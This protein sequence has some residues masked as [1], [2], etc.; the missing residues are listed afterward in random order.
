MTTRKNSKVITKAPP[1]P[2]IQAPKYDLPWLQSELRTIIDILHANNDIKTKAQLFRDYQFSSSRFYR[3]ITKYNDN[4]RVQEYLKKI[5]EI[6]ES[7]LIE[8]GLEKKNFPFVIFLLKN[9]YGYQDKKEVETE[10]THVFK[11][12]RGNKVID[13]DPKQVKQVLNKPIAPN[14]Q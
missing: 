10:T 14:K 7:R 2:P 3:Y 13:I 8:H 6:L 4:K 11:V 9:F 1:T 12:A 5:D